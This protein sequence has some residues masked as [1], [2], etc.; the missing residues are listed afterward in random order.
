MRIWLH[1]VTGRAE[2]KLTFDVQTEVAR[3]MGFKEEAGEAAVER[4]MRRYFLTARDVGGLTRAFGK[5]P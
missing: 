5:Q 1:L 2:E 3:R 4:F